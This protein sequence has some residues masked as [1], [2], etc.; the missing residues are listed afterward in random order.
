METK[1]EVILTNSE[2]IVLPSQNES[3]LACLLRNNI[4]IDHSCGGNGTCGTCRIFVVE[5]I[6]NINEPNQIESEM[7]TDRKFLENERLACQCRPIGSLK[8][9]IT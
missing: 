2:R 7:I 9:K 8:I 3:I 5:N 4:E 1:I 6:E